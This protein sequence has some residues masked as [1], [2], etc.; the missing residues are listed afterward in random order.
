MGERVLSRSLTLTA[1]TIWL[2]ANLLL[3]YP[4]YPQEGS[5][6]KIVVVAYVCGT[7]APVL[8]LFGVSVLAVLTLF[9][10]FCVWYEGVETAAGVVATLLELGADVNRDDGDPEVRY[11]PL[12]S[13]VAN[14]VNLPV[15]LGV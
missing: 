15:N 11:T 2:R 6:L 13:A 9:L 1:L 10:P 14:E 12:H 3:Q 7:Q 5:Q 8:T 4:P